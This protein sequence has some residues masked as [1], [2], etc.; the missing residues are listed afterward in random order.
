MAFDGAIVLQ[1]QRD[2]PL[3]GGPQVSQSGEHCQRAYL[4]VFSSSDFYNSRIACLVVT[5]TGGGPQYK[6]SH[7]Y[8]PTEQ[9]ETPKPGQRDR[10]QRLTRHR[11]CAMYVL[12]TEAFVPS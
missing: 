5:G 12:P 11:A 3:A 6:R 2:A 9:P 10:R 7:S 4:Y 1:R 8:E